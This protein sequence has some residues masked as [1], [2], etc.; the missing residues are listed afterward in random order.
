M[1]G[2]A[3]AE[4]TETVATFLSFWL[5]ALVFRLQSSFDH[6]SCLF[7]FQ[8][9]SLPPPVF[10]LRFVELVARLVEKKSAVSISSPVSLP[11]RRLVSVLWTG[12][13]A[14]LA[15]FWMT[16]LYSYT[17]CFSLRHY[18]L[19]TTMGD[20]F[21][22]FHTHPHSPPHVFTLLISPSSQ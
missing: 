14:L 4:Q 3:R 17:W 11:R 16:S 18:L 8:C 19:I 7:P 6:R 20:G 2:G 15:R 22:I 21:D 13:L 5:F 9:L 12:S 1:G 10:I